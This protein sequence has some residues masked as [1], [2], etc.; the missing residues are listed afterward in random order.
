MPSAAAQE[1]RRV[2]FTISLINRV[3]RNNDERIGEMM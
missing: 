1:M 3:E 2:D